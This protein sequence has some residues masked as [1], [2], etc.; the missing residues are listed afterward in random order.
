MSAA[1]RLFTGALTTLF[2]AVTLGL[3]F[4]TVKCITEVFKDVSRQ[5]GAEDVVMG[6]AVSIGLFGVTLMAA[7]GAVWMGEKTIHP[8]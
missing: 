4:H 5:Y 6:S 1:E 8:D 3:G 7:A 2:T